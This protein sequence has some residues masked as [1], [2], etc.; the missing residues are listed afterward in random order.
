MH[1]LSANWVGMP[2]VLLRL[3][4]SDECDDVRRLA[5]ADDG[6]SAANVAESSGPSPPASSRPLLRT[7][8]RF[9]EEGR[10]GAGAH[11]Q[12]HNMGVAAAHG[13]VGELPADGGLLE[14]GAD[15]NELDGH[16]PPHLPVQRQQHEPA[17]ASAP[18][19]TPP[20][21]T[22]R[23][24][25]PASTAALLSQP[26][27]GESVGA[28]SAPGSVP[29]AQL[30]W[31]AVVGSCSGQPCGA[32]SVVVGTG[33]DHSALGAGVPKGQGEHLLMLP[34]RWYRGWPASGS[35]VGQGVGPCGMARPCSTA[36]APLLPAVCFLR[37][38][39]WHLR[40]PH[41]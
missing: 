12:L 31:A 40:S 18:P 14:V 5:V 30:Q 8:R 37:V 7:C 36:H 38:P 4:S 24:A 29:F 2:Q 32:A 3:T 11:Q 15:G 34:S 39:F 9:Q 17:A 6:R 27:R 10:G 23:A 1:Q 22:H 26:H 35:I 19:G 25:T 41:R 33:R 21:R 13:L 20:H 28:V 16:L